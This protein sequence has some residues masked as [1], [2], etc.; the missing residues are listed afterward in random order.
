MDRS[1]PAGV[2]SQIFHVVFASLV[3]RPSCL[4]D[5]IQRIVPWLSFAPI[6]TC[7]SSLPSPTHQEQDLRVLVPQS[8]CVEHAVEPSPCGR[9]VASVHVRGSFLHHARSTSSSRA[10]H[11]FPSDLRASLRTSRA[12]TSSRVDAR[13]RSHRSAIRLVGFVWEKTSGG[14]QWTERN[15]DLRDGKENK[16]ERRRTRMVVMMKT[17][18]HAWQSVCVDGWRRC[19]G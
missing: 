5:L 8:K 11:R 1:A 6:A 3:L 2:S 18:L 15:Q 12:R 9:F 17:H 19:L 14:G 16:T 7:T 13:W 10:L 4:V